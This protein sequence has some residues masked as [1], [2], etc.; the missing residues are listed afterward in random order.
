VEHLPWLGGLYINAGHGSKGLL[1][2]PLCAEIIAAML[3]HE[4]LPVDA[5]LAR[6][7]DPNRFLLRQRGL[8]RL[9]GAAIG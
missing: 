4:P 1:T 5:G 6:T 3:E 8:K 7:L 2:A 9:I